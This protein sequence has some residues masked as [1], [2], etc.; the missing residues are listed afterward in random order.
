[1]CFSNELL[2]S[3]V[4]V[5]NKGRLPPTSRPCINQDTSRRGFLQRG[6]YSCTFSG[7]LKIVPR[8]R[9][10]NQTSLLA[11]FTRKQEIQSH[12]IL[13]QLFTKL[14]WLDLSLSRKGHLECSIKCFPLFH[15]MDG[16][17]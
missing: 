15:K 8:G 12:V 9:M 17:N 5:V 10:Y 14:T 6:D 2:L 13:M 11:V 3:A 16:E 1:M 4:H 7:T